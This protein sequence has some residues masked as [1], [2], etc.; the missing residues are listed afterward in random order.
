MHTTQNENLFAHVT[1]FQYV[2][3]T[4][5]RS[6]LLNENVHAIEVMVEEGWYLFTRWLVFKHDGHNCV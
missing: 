3:K 1:F 4:L 5:T 6:H 2:G